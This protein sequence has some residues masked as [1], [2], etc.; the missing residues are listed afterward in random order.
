[1][2]SSHYL[3]IAQIDDAPY[4]FSFSYEKNF[5][6]EDF[7]QDKVEI[8]GLDRVKMNCSGEL[9]KK[10]NKQ[11]FFKGKLRGFFC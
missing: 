6:E 9:S 10:T 8:Q 11:I 4:S 1:M 7:L 5:C 3:K 2:Q